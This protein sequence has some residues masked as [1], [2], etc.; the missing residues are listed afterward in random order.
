M[1]AKDG[2]IIKL[3]WHSWLPS[4]THSSSHIF[5]LPPPPS[6]NYM[7]INYLNK[8]AARTVCQPLTPEV[9]KLFEIHY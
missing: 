8:P 1:S 7:E 4:K 3:I 6:L 5:F 9:N 2:A